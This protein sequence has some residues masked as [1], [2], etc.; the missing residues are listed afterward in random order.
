MLMLMLMP[1]LMP[2]P[3]NPDP[4]SPQICKMYLD[5][6][7]VYTPSPFP[8]PACPPKHLYLQKGSLHPFPKTH[9]LCITSMHSNR[10]PLPH[11]RLRFEESRAVDFWGGA[12]LGGGGG[13]VGGEGWG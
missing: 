12:A 1:M 13:G 9:T 5:P 3:L 4:N 8:S 7:L 10:T 6:S 2:M 11:D